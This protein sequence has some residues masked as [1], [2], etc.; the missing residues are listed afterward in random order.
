MCFLFVVCFPISVYIHSPMFASIPF[1]SLYISSCTGNILLLQPYFFSIWIHAHTSFVVHVGFFL[2]PCL[3]FLC[4][5]R[6]SYWLENCLEHKQPGY[7]LYTALRMCSIRS[8]RENSNN[9]VGQKAN[10]KKKYS[11]LLDNS[12][13]AHLTRSVQY[14]VRINGI[15]TLRCL[16][17]L[18]RTRIGAHYTFFSSLLLLHRRFFFLLVVSFGS[19]W[20]ARHLCRNHHENDVHVAIQIA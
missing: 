6:S 3:T 9:T 17:I 19:V 4:W 10:E 11:A 7:F 13:E 20:L 2:N 8:R 14:A 15:D 12:L 18:T 5:P 16:F 1:F